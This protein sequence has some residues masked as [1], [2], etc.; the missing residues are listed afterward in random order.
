MKLL[1]ILESELVSFKRMSDD[2]ESAQDAG[3]ANDTG[4]IDPQSDEQQMGDAEHSFGDDET[5][6]TPGEEQD[7]DRQGNIRTIKGAHLVYKRKS[8][9]NLY[10]ELWIFKQ[11]QMD[12]WTTHTYD[13][14]LAG[15]DIPKG[16]E[17]SEDGT[18]SVERYE[19]GDPQNTLVFVEIKGL[20][21]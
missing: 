17:N 10:D 8:E 3:L 15:T 12:Q 19:V 7:P 6:Q 11:N 16:K 21:N 20:A 13:A 18:Q 2:S 14:I 1:A 5:P 4:T 9:N